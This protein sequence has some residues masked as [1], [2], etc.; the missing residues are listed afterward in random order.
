MYLGSVLK[1]IFLYENPGPNKTVFLY[2]N[3]GPGNRFIIL[4]EE[5]SSSEISQL[6]LSYKTFMTLAN[7]QKSELGSWKTHIEEFSVEELETK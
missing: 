3:P 4:T 1:T 5:R 6:L 2:E 7:T